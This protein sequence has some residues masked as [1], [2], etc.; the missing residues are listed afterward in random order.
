MKELQEILQRIEG[1]APG[2]R[3]ILATVVGVQGSG[4]R[5]AGARMLID[6]DGKSIG[7]VSGGCLE[8]D[9]IERAKLRLNKEGPTV[10]VY[11]SIKDKDS[12]FGLQTGCR[13]V[14][15]ILLEPAIDNGLF[16]F[17]RTCFSRRER[18][19]IATLFSATNGTDLPIATRLFWL[20]GKKYEVA[21]KTGRGAID[22]VA[23]KIGQDAD[24]SIAEDRSRSV[25][26]R[27]SKGELEFF[28]EV[29]KPPT[30]L[31]IFGAGHDALPL[32]A[33]AKHLGWRVSVVDHR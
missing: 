30:S 21:I 3:A 7:T 20:D 23:L 22:D 24:I 1:L 26:Y 29:V 27:T 15:R 19:A 5:L 4:Y 2:E 18:G 17:V 9:I 13:G 31:L 12:I 25:I 10:V 8:A 16:G 14:V 6:E 28:I 33:F 32:A 11:D